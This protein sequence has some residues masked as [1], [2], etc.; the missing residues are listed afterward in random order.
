[1]L[2]EEYIIIFLSLSSI[3]PAERINLNFYRTGHANMDAPARLTISRR[4]QLTTL[5]AGEDLRHTQILVLG[6][7]G[8]WLYLEWS[9]LS[10]VN[11]SNFFGF[12]WSAKTGGDWSIIPAFASSF[13]D[14]FNSIPCSGIYLT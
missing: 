1:M 6:N 8:C 5:F 3:R 7:T 12:M 4:G 10:G 14:Q 13:K 11:W 2:A 9:L